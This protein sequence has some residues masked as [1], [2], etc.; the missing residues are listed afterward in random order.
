MKSPRILFLLLILAACLAGTQGY[1]DNQRPNVIVI[2]SD[3]QGYADAGF[4]NVVADGVTTPNLDRLAASGV[5]FENAYASSPVCSNSRLALSTGR[6]QQRWGAYH[7]GQGGL[8]SDE[9]TIAEMMREAGYRTM[10]VG[11]THLNNGPKQ[12]PMKHGFDGY[13]GFEHHSWDFELLSEKDVAAYER[14]LP[15]SHQRARMAPFGP[16]HRNSETKESY[17]NTTTTEVFGDESVNFIEQESDQPFYLQLEFNAVHTPLT[18]GPKQLRDKYGIPDRPFDREAKV[19]DYPLWDPVVQPNY[20]EW[21]GQTCHLKIPDPYGR[22]IYLA[23]LELMDTQIGRILD[24]LE[25]KGLTNDTLIFFSVDNGGSDQSYANNGPNNAFKYCLMDGGIKVPMVMAWPGQFPK[26]KRLEAV[27]THRDLYA[28][29]SEVTGIAPK[30]PLDG[31]SLLP[32]ISG[33]V[34]VLHQEAIF[35]D[36]G[37]KMVNWVVRDGDWKMVYREEG[38]DY[39]AYQLDE[40]GLVK[41]EFRMVTIPSGL[42]LYDLAADPGES[43]NLA[44]KNPERTQAMEKQYLEW[45]A[46]MGEPISGRQAK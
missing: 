11:K 13:L 36:S 26:G 25:E 28:S 30:K 45:R 8:P 19:W 37:N 9:H 42:Q 21:Y 15:G 4:Q 35:W 12:D 16:L 1:A 27:V 10:K 20:A 3:D 18:R 31:K 39:E 24:T 7:Y 14:K 6:Y 34:E 29:L 38:R 23:H 32:L 22:K 41:D 44:S 17:E 43:E 33:E 40:N 2:V 46:T 5:V